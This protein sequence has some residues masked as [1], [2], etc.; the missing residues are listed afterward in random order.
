[1]GTRVGGDDNSTGNKD[2][3]FWI[4]DQWTITVDPGVSTIQLRRR[5]DGYRVD[6]IYVTMNN[7]NPNDAEPNSESPQAGVTYAWDFDDGG[8]SS[9][10]D[11]NHTYTSAGEY[12]ACLVVTD[13]SN[14]DTDEEC[15]TITVTDP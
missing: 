12:E 9:L 2:E 5:E 15:E 1:M 6:R 11:P 3:W 7:D 4:N 10:Q 8:T 14:G 13:S